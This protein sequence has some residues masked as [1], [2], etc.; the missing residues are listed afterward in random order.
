MTIRAQDKSTELGS[1]LRFLALIC[2]TDGGTTQRP[3]KLGALVT[4]R[5]LY[6]QRHCDLRARI[7]FLPNG[8]R[9]CILVVW[10]GIVPDNH[11]LAG[12]VR[13]TRCRGTMGAP[14]PG[15]EADCPVAF[16][17]TLPTLEDRRYRED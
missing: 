11:P 13:L 9:M 16:L 14:T 10:P 8:P 2:L 1:I 4:I 12:Q 17:T 3:T 6:A 15:R 5:A 7:R